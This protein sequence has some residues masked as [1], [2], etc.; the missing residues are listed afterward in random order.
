MVTIKKGV[1]SEK[2]DA[3]VKEELV[4]KIMDSKGGF[5]GLVSEQVGCVFK[6]TTFEPK[7]AL[8]FDKD[9]AD[10]I[11]EKIPVPFTGVVITEKEM[12]E[13]PNLYVDP[14]AGYRRYRKL[15]KL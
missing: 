7:K 14:I 3:Q 5:K 15:Y 13:L 11:K 2:A 10:L 8:R 12:A 1:L 6:E 4:V 9:I